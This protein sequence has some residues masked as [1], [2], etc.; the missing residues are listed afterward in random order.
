MKFSQTQPKVLITQTQPKVLITHTMKGIFGKNK[1]YRKQEIFRKNLNLLLFV[2]LKLAMTFVRNLLFF[3][4]SAWRWTWTTW[5]QGSDVRCL[6]LKGKWV[7]MFRLRCSCCLCCEESFTET[8]LKLQ[9]FSFLFVSSKL[10]YLTEAK[11]LSPFSFQRFLLRH[12]Q[13]YA[14]FIKAGFEYPKN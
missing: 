8:A 6:S 12:F 10:F 5:K 7:S 13:A 4:F 14:W 2:V 9:S 3:S 11:Y 1:I